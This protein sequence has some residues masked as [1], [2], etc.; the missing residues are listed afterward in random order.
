MTTATIPT[1]A[2]QGSTFYGNTRSGS[3]SHHASRRTAH[4]HGIAARSTYRTHSADLDRRTA[5]AYTHRDAPLDA[6]VGR[7]V[8]TSVPELG[9]AERAAL[10]AKIEL[11]AQLAIDKRDRR[12]GRTLRSALV[13]VVRSCPDP[14]L[15]AATIRSIRRATVRRFRAADGSVLAHVQLLAMAQAVDAGDAEGAALTGSLVAG[16]VLS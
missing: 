11:A 9:P 13:S 10:A 3:S 14:R 5:E 12:F 6:L 4:A 15:Q 1:P 2:N 16:V 8:R 7:A